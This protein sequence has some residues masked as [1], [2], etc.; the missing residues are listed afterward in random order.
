M[1]P[2][3]DD[4][5]YMSDGLSRLRFSN[6]SGL[7]SV[8]NSFIADPPHAPVTTLTAM[9]GFWLLGPEPIAAYIANS[10][11]VLLFLVFLT[12]M[13]R[14]I[15]N[16]LDRAL[17]IAT[18]LFVPVVQ[19]MVMEFRPD[20]PAGLI[21]GIALYTI[22]TIDLRQATR[23]R[24]FGLAALFVAATITKPTAFI[25]V[26]PALVGALLLVAVRSIIIDR[27][28]TRS[29]LA[30]IAQIFGAY[31]L[32]M[33]PVS[34]IWGAPTYRY[35]YDALFTYAD[36]WRSSGDIQ[37]HLLY[38]STGIGGQVA[39]GRFLRNGLALICVDA[40]IWAVRRQSRTRGVIEYYLLVAGLYLALAISGEKTLYQG[41]FFYIPF[42]IAFAAASVRILV[43]VKDILGLKWL[44]RASLICVAAFYVYK[45]PLASYYYGADPDAFK[46]PPMI[47]RVTTQIGEVSLANAD[48]ATCS[49]RPLVVVFTD[50]LP[51]PTELVKFE[52]AKIG[53]PIAIAPAF[54]SRDLDEMKR[55]AERGD[56]VLIADPSRP[57]PS[58][59][60]PGLAYNQDLF[61]Y[62]KSW[63]GA[64]RFNIAGDNGKPIWMIVNPR[65]VPPSRTGN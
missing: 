12:W 44:A 36:V 40:V 11:V 13:S 61:A 19:A 20:L 48:N 8:V 50:A 47:N 21:V 16:T 1:I 34:L 3:Y 31:I 64:E 59:W 62:L 41:S 35:V 28:H 39:L 53:I 17:F 37:F 60:L 51:I 18:F 38:N 43:F 56:I 23:A 42:V 4:I 22:C 33:L 54:M 46:L 24:L 10:W 7:R 52:A 25:L 5:N 2:I 65:C 55:F 63:Q 32:L 58:R 49:D 15:G 9:M 29:N 14:P 30:K 57:S 26:M 27:E 6:G 45:L